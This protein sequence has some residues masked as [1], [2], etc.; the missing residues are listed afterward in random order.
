MYEGE[1]GE[2]GMSADIGADGG[3]GAT[4]VR[5]CDGNLGPNAMQG[6]KDTSA[7]IAHHHTG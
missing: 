7:E 2:K 4:H 5:P 6:V 1:D 3:L